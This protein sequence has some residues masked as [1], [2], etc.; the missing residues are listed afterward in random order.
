MDTMALVL[1]IYFNI[2]CYSQATSY[3][4]GIITSNQN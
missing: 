2:L 3:S 1:G 4:S